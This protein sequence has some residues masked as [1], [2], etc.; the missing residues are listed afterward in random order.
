MR[1]VESKVAELDLMFSSQK[2]TSL[3][4]GHQAVQP[5][6]ASDSVIIGRTR[7]I[8]QNGAL[9]ISTASPRIQEQRQEMAG[10]EPGTAKEEVDLPAVQWV[11][12]LHY[13]LEQ[14]QDEAIAAGESEVFQGCNVSGM[15]EALEVLAAWR[16]ELGLEA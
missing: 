14:F 11:E 16:A 8:Y 7:A 1:D 4:S 13:Y 6:T 5:L 2:L 12:G 10:G 9:Q 3:T 15:R